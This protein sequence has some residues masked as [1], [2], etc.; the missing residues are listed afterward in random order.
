MTR[1]R[2][3]SRAARRWSS[4]SSVRAVGLVIVAAGTTVVARHAREN[5]ALAIESRLVQDLRTA[6]DIVARDLRRAGYW[7]AS[8]SGVRSDDGSGWALDQSLRPG[9]A[10]RPRRRTRCG[11]ASRATPSEDGSVDGNERFGFRLRSGAIELQLGDGNWQALTDPATLTVTAFEVEPR[12]E[13]TSLERILRPSPAPPAAATCPPRQQVRSFA[14]A[15]EARAV[16]RPGRAPQR[17]R[18]ARDCGTARWSAAA[19]PEC[20]A[21]GTHRSSAPPARRRGAGRH[22]AARVGDADRGRGGQPQRD[23]RDA[24]LGQP[25]PLDPVVRSRRGRPRTGRWPASTTTRRS[26]TTACRAPTR[27]RRRFASATCATTAPAS[28]PPPGTTPA[29]AVPLQAACV[30]GESG[31]VPCQLPGERRGRRRR[32]RGQRRPRRASRCSSPTAR[33]RASSAP[34]ATGCTRRGA[35]CTDGVRTPATRRPRGSRSR[36]AWSPGLRA[37]TGGGADGRRQPRRRRQRAR[38]AQPRRGLRRHGDPRRRQRRRRCAAPERAC[39]ARRSTARVVAGDAQLAA[40]G[41]ATASSPAGSA[42]TGAAWRA[43]PAATPVACAGE[44][45]VDGQ[46]ARSPPAPASWPWKA[47]PRSQGPLELGTP[48]RPVVLRVDGA[49]RLRG[50]VTLHGV[51]VAG[52]LEWRDAAADSGALV[53]GAALVEGSYLGRRR[54]RRRPRRERCSPGCSDETGS[55]ARVNGSWKDF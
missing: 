37:V 33:G 30:R 1:T 14:V 15:I 11:S 51:V 31:C 50:A 3:S 32:S 5:R 6:A 36:S 40:L 44:C 18:R 26:A 13:E 25:V 17:P 20:E 28:S 16:R 46:P 4:C 7:G 27:R 45:A 43:Q 38:G 35:A 39:R 49:L 2:R 22:D 9:R 41:R 21:A 12:T 48:E 54:R 34:I 10:R 8:A 24:R 29:R 53:R 19:R 52:A 42:W 55:F 47:A 23:R